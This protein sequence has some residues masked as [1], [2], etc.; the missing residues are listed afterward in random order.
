MI[1]WGA[2]HMRE[3]IQVSWAEN[4]N[5]KLV[6]LRKNYFLYSPDKKSK[7]WLILLFRKE[8]VNCTTHVLNTDTW[9]HMN[10]L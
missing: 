6:T 9:T 7:N 3:S 8:T 1:A 2:K 4:F 10:I 5:Y